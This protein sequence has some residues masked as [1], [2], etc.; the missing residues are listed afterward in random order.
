VAPA[1]LEGRAFFEHQQRKR[2]AAQARLTGR[3]QQRP[4]SA[5]SVMASAGSAVTQPLA[6]LR[7]T[8]RLIVISGPQAGEAFDL[9]PGELILGR[10]EGS[11]I[12]LRDPMVSHHHALLRTQGDQLIIEDLRS[13]N[14]TMVNEAGISFPTALAPGDVI[15][16][17]DSRLRLESPRGW[18]SGDSASAASPCP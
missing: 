15:T 10:E 18:S 14:G 7:V 4:V 8:P 12:W 1:G 11:A 9:G 5:T 17:G 3:P 2:R 6:A 13:T 16:L